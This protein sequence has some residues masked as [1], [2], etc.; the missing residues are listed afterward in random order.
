MLPMWLSRCFGGSGGCGATSGAHCART[1]VKTTARMKPITAL[2]QCNR[3]NVF[4]V[5]ILKTN[6][7]LRPKSPAVSS[8]LEVEVKP[9]QQFVGVDVGAARSDQRSGS[10]LMQPVELVMP[11]KT[12]PAGHE[13]VVAHADRV[14]GDIAEVGRRGKAAAPASD[15]TR[16]IRLSRHPNR[17]VACE[18]DQLR[19]VDVVRL[20]QYAVP[21][22]RLGTSRQKRA[23]E[24]VVG[25]RAIDEV[26]VA[27]PKPRV[28]PAMLGHNLHVHVRAEV[29]QAKHA[30]PVE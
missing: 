6:S 27:L 9:C 16:S 7:A 19:T 11:G 26:A 13:R 5:S 10:I 21:G 15:A 22:G 4:I 12:G 17:L 25:G 23:G 20:D 18:E 1:P 3:L 28:I 29:E 30:L 8:S 2:R 24:V 14:G